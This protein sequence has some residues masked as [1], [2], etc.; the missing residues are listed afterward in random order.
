[1]IAKCIKTLANK[2]CYKV[3]NLFSILYCDNL[4]GKETYGKGI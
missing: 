1:M 2:D 4:G 3:N